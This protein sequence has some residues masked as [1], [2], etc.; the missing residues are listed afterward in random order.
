MHKF[1]LISPLNIENLVQAE[2]IEKW[3][4]F[5]DSE[6]PVINKVEGGIEVEC[7]MHEGLM[8]NTFLKIPTRILLRLKEQKCR[9][10]PKL[11]NII[12]K[13]KWKEYLKSDEV[14]WKITTKKSRLINTTKI[15]NSCKEALVKYFNANKLPQKILDQKETFIN[16]KI[17]LRIEDDLLQLSLDTSGESLH[18][19]GGDSFRGLASI[20]STLAS[21]MLYKT[22]KEIHEPIN[23]VDPMCGSATFLKEARDFYLP[24]HNR[25]FAFENWLERI[26]LKE[27]TRKFPIDNFYGFDI[28][29]EIIKKQKGFKLKQA[30]LFKDEN[31]IENS[32]VI[33]NP[34]YGKRVKLDRERQKYFHDLIDAIKTNI[35]PKCI[36]IIL[37][38]DIKINQFKSKEKIFNSGIWVNHFIIYP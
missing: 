26:E 8:L 34:P 11:F 24:N 31:L 10:L 12:Q 4:M 27:N 37:P 2:L 21:A 6:L 13:I 18:I 28:D 5:Y 7:E 15:E 23:L 16:Q 33:C 25:K 17:F 1:F 32:I 22:L 30:N 38:I 20:R 35:N 19:R 3:P 29:A 9:D 36:S 14:T